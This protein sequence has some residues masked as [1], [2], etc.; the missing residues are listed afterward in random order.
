MSQYI[1][2]MCNIEIIVAAMNRLG[3]LNARIGELDY[4]L[5]TFPN[6]ILKKAERNN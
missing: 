1:A 6:E 4:I 5:R 3:S 2:Y